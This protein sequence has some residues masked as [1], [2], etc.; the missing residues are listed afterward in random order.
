[1]AEQAGELGTDVSWVSPARLPGS[2]ELLVDFHGE[3]SG[4]DELTWGQVG[5]WQGMEQTGQSGTMGDVAPLPPGT[6][7]ELMQ[8]LMTF[9]MGRHQSLRTRLRLVPGGRPRQVCAESGRLIIQV[10]DAGEADPAEVAAQIKQ[11]FTEVNFDYENEWPVRQAIVTAGGELRFG[12]TVYLHTAIDATGLAV[13]LAD[14][15]ARDP[16]TGQAG[17]VL[18]MQPLEQTRRQQTPAVQRHSV[19]SLKHLENVMRTANPDGFGP[20]NYDGPAAFQM[21][22]FRSPATALA[23]PRIV[24]EHGINSSSAVLAVFALGVAQH[25]RVSIFSAMMMVSN[26]FRPGFAD[27]VS[28]LVQ[29]SPYMIDVADVTLGQTMARAGSSLLHTYK[30]AY[31]DPY[32]QDALVDR[33]NADLGVDFDFCCFYN[34][35]R[36]QREVA[37][38]ELATDEQLAEAVAAS[39]WEWMQQADMS[40]RKLFANVDDP[41]GC[42]EFQMS[43]DTR[44]FDADDLLAVLRGIEAAAVQTVLEPDAATG[45]VGRVQ[46]QA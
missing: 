27:S 9:V 17:P 34:D 19:A 8:E 6:T 36:E 22:R 16:V 1:M 21:M 32:E 18:G 33:V 28:A 3:G 4:E 37:G 11:H 15:F 39:S 35:R 26:R 40:T 23:L 12:V 13:L 25:T 45:L 14:M 43:V 20:P 29:I 38:A 46:Q 24:A 44:H 5:F 42:I 30:N 31:Y 7:F 41:P 2:T 10:V